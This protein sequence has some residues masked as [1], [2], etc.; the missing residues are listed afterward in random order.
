M[1]RPS[2]WEREKERHRDKNNCCFT[3]TLREKERE[4]E[5]ETRNFCEIQRKKERE[6][7]TERFV[8]FFYY[9]YLYI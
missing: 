9:F 8:D 1:C 4:R 6:R 7:D 5:T 3:K 2:V